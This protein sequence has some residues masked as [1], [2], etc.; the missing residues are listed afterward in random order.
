M[1]G[2]LFTIFFALSLISCISEERVSD[3][4]ILPAFSFQDYLGNE[5]NSTKLKGSYVYIQFIK[6]A[7]GSGE[8][9][10]KEILNDVQSFEKL[11]FII[12]LHDLAVMNLQRPNQG[13]VHLLIDRSGRLNDFFQVPKCCDSYIIYNPQGN[14]M[15]REVNDEDYRQNIRPILEEITE[16]PNLIH[17]DSAYKLKKIK[18]FGLFAALMRELGDDS[19][20][21]DITLL[22]NRV[23][24]DCSIAP[25]VKKL[26]YIVSNNKSIA[27]LQI[28]VSEDF[29]KVDIENLTEALTISTQVKVVS[30]DVAYAW[31][32]LRKDVP[33][34]FDNI[35]IIFEDASG[36]G[37]VFSQNNLEEMLAKAVPI[38]K[39]K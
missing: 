26:D 8:K 27:S 28:F 19:L 32:E 39:D 22:L 10:L 31:A 38:V 29:S 18:E 3:S 16:E 20:F 5:V 24:T 25:A 11:I 34:I 4:D 30:K 23:C 13:K 12:V 33:K 6:P 1:R 36:N 15:A 21:P 7:I 37:Q 2:F 35:F 17:F 14:V 9:K